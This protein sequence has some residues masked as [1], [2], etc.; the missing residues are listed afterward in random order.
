[1]TSEYLVGEALPLINEAGTG[2]LDS[3]HRVAPEGMTRAPRVEMEGWGVS[4]LPQAS[5]PQTPN[6]GGEQTSQAL[7]CD[8]ATPLPGKQRT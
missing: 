1:M 3:G 5:D 6:E 2:G 8:A 7:R 4:W